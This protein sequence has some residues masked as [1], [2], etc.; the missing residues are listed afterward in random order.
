MAFHP[1]H[2]PETVYWAY[3]LG[4]SLWIF[5]V[6]VAL[7]A[8]ITNID[9]L[10]NIAFYLHHPELS[11]GRALRKHEKKL[12]AE[13]KSYRTKIKVM[14]EDFKK[15]DYSPKHKTPGFR[16][17]IPDNFDDVFG[18]TSWKVEEGF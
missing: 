7:D 5:V 8:K 18:D 3:K 15:I 11:G 2:L 16:S 9:A 17:M 4:P 1:E 12:I 10:T 13:W 6:V 14:A